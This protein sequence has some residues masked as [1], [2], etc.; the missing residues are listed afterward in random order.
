MCGGVSHTAVLLPGL[1]HHGGVWRVERR[2][3][4][5][6]EASQ[7]RQAQS[8]PSTKHG[9]AVTVT[10]VLWYSKHVAG[11]AGQFKVD[12]SHTCAQGDNAACPWRK[13]KKNKSHD[14]GSIFIPSDASSCHSLLNKDTCCPSV[15]TRGGALYT[16]HLTSHEE[17]KSGHILHQIMFLAAAQH[18]YDP[19]KQDDGHGHAH[20]TCRHPLEVCKAPKGQRQC[21]LGH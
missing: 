11:V 18:A 1:V 6:Q 5:T 12:P 2:S 19:A 3:Q 17:K 14:S 7:Q 20:K 15:G 13:R 21:L 9:P 10:D 4:C 8:T 16:Q